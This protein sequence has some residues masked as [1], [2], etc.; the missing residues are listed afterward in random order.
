MHRVAGG[1]I[2]GLLLLL[3]AVPARADSAADQITSFRLKH[4]EVRVVR[5][6]TLDRI[7]MDQAKA[8]AAKDDL[9]HDALG[10]FN[11]RVAPAGAGRAA[12]NIA[13]GYDNFEKT[14]GQWIDSSGHRKNLL[15]HNASRVGIASAR[16]ASGKRTYWAMVI[17]GD[18]EPKGK[19]KG[20]GKKD[21]E[22]LVAVKREA[23]PASKPKSESKP[24]SSNCHIKLLGLCI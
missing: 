11:R 24:K 22:P 20:K 13:Y 5:D 3:A 17:A 12:E 15:L 1:L 4:G 16:T 14:L 19:D 10:P 23:P 2:A 6:S 7:A 8:M 21:G 9:S 18:Y